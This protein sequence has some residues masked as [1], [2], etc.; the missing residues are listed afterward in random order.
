MAEI[1]KNKFTY[2]RNYY[3]NM[4]K[5]HVAGTAAKDLNAMEYE[6]DFFE[7]GEAFD[8]EYSEYDFETSPKKRETVKPEIYTEPRHGKKEKVKVLYKFR[9][10]TL[11]MTVVSLGALVLASYRYI[12]VRAE[13]TQANKKIEVAKT[14]L[15][16]IQNKNSALMS[17]LDVEMDRNYIYAMAVGKLGM[18]YPKEND[19]I[20]YTK[21]DEGYV[22]QYHDIP[23]LK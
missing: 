10:F 1:R 2:D 6:E 18:K 13:I 22:R 7:N 5:V 15:K 4:D 16:D 19:I 12:E 8:E 20:Y 3:E 9:L 11:L 14:E 23:E 17:Q 21:A